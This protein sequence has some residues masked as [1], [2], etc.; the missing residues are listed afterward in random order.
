MLLLRA[1]GLA[2]G[3]FGSLSSRYPMSSSHLAVSIDF[4]RSHRRTSDVQDHVARPFLGR[5]DAVG[6]LRSPL[7][8]RPCK[9]FREAF[10]ILFREVHD[11]EVQVEF[12]LRR[13]AAMEPDGNG[14][15]ELVLELR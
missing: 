8:I 7:R 6:H 2:R 9:D 10:T 14:P 4:R 1:M 5:V 11:P 3:D 15:V 13:F 12:V